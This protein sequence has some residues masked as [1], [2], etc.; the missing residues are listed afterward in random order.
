MSSRSPQDS[1]S[2]QFD[3][4]QSVGGFS[5]P[6]P[7]RFQPQERS[8]PLTNNRM[9]LS[10]QNPY[11]FHLH[12]HASYGISKW[13]RVPKPR[14][15]FVYPSALQGENPLL[16]SNNAKPL[17]GDSGCNALPDRILAVILNGSIN[18]RIPLHQGN[19]NP[20]ACACFCNIV[21]SLLNDSIECCLNL[22]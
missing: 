9:V 17:S 11:L 3:G 21:Q 7:Y 6:P 1:V 20:S 22:W 15:R 18:P 14:L 19:L 4:L 12:S 13:I 5:E 2:L 10:Q 8:D 16:N